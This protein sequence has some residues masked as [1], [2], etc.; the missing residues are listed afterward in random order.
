MYLI[1]DGKK[2][3][4]NKCCMCKQVSKHSEIYKNN[5]Y[6][7]IGGFFFDLYCFQKIE[8]MNYSKYEFSN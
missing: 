7:K 1:I 4:I 5:I 2:N 8:E 6:I 3:E